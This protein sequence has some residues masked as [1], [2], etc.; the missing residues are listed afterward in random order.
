MEAQTN[1][2]TKKE[3]QKKLTTKQRDF[4]ELYMLSMNATQAAKEAGYSAHSAL[5]QGSRLLTKADVQNYIGF[6]QD[7]RSAKH[8]INADRI[9]TELAKVAFSEI[10]DSV[11]VVDGRLRIKDIGEMNNIAAVQEI[12][13]TYN[14]KDG[15]T[16]KVKNYDKLRA[17]ELLGRHCGMFKEG[18]IIQNTNTIIAPVQVN[19]QVNHRQRGQTIIEND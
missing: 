5:E 11:E 6:L 10:S 1:K 16:R 15:L 17:L 12:S 18:A 13:E 4:C 9:A 14:K 19:I 2:Q 3:L 7:E 8:E